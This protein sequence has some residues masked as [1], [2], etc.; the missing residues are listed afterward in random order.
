MLSCL[1]QEAQALVVR[2]GGLR[3]WL[4]LS[5]AGAVVPLYLGML[6]DLPL[7][8]IQVQVPRCTHLLYVLQA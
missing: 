4:C 8:S 3:K 2:V 5:E 7:K 6:E 1:A